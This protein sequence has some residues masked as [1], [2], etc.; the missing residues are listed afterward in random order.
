MANLIKEAYAIAIENGATIEKNRVTLCSI[1][2][3]GKITRYQVWS[4]RTR[5]EFHSVYLE[6]EPALLKF[7]ELS[8]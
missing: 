2:S 7:I 8:S 1:P 5:T 6:L 4:N 3:I